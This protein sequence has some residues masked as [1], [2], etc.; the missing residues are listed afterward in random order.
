MIN[1]IA[2]AKRAETHIAKERE[3]E[4]ER[5]RDQEPESNARIYFFELR[6]STQKTNN[7]TIDFA[8]A[9]PTATAASATVSFFVLYRFLCTVSR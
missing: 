4:R 9:S 5:A 1:K 7:P 6:D 2:C 3:K 8:S